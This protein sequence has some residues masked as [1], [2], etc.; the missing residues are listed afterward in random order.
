MREDQLLQQAISAARAGR[1]LTARDLFLEVVELN[2]RCEVAWM[3]LTG[4][5][6]DL[7]DCIYACEQVVA[8]NPGNAGAQAYLSQLLAKKQEALDVEKLH[9]E[10]QLQTARRLADKGENEQALNLLRTLTGGN[11]VGADAWRLIAGLS[12]DLNEQTHALEKYLELKPDDAPARQE[13]KRLSHFQS[14][15]LDLAA[16]YEERG[17]IDKAI[18][19]YELAMVNHKSKK[20]WDTIYW[21]IQRLENLRH[22]KITHISPAVSVA[23]LTAGPPLLYVLLTLVQLG[24]NPFAENA[25]LLWFGFLWV[26]LGG[27]FIALASVRSRHPLWSVLFKDAGGGG[28]RAARSLVST[29]GWILVLLPH[30][31]LLLIAYNRLTDSILFRIR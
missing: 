28:S 21:K 29:A 18:R 11:P 12:P 16:S 30:L 9:M 20:E 10:E 15:P 23:R 1:E 19:T 22:E 3:W 25:V 27:F 5:L 14:N 4:L 2:P 8:L 13:L 31:L 26:L 6:D 24:F 7:D 17:E